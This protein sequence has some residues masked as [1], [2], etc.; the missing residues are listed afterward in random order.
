MTGICLETPN[1]LL[2]FRNRVL[3]FKCAHTSAVDGV[4]NGFTGVTASAACNVPNFGRTREPR[5]REA[6]CGQRT[7]A[8]QDDETAPIL[9][10][11]APYIV[12]S[13]RDRFDLLRPESSASSV[14]EPGFSR[15]IIV[16]SSRL[17]CES[18]FA[19]LSIEVNHTVGSP[20]V[21]LCSPRAS[22]PE[23]APRVDL[24]RIPVPGRRHRWPHRR[25][26][27]LVETSHVGRP[28]AQTLRRPN[29]SP[30]APPHAPPSPHRARSGCAHP[31]RART[32]RAVPRYRRRRA[33]R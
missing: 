27:C 21:G 11:H 19:K 22:R 13:V 1:K 30:A 28:P 10:L 31:S 16:R 14:T 5:T 7:K 15:P 32:A 4:R 20:R 24:R 17:R 8:R 26:R 9:F 25:G 18:T 33:R 23:T 6:G 29:P 3:R 12:L 2:Y